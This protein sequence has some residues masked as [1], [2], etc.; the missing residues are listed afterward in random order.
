MIITYT[1]QLE[2]PPRD[3]EVTLGFTIIGEKAGGSQRLQLKSGV[4]R[5]VD[6]ADWEK[7]KGMPLVGDLLALGALKVQD[8][9]EVIEEAGVAKGGLEKLP[10]KEALDAIHGTFDLDLLKE[11]D[12]AENRVRIKNAISKRVKAVTEGEG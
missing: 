8:D 4:N 3:K 6:P 1:P 9:V 7:I 5:D 2:N 10:V 11:W 12:R